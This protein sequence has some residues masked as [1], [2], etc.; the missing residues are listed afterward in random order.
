MILMVNGQIL[1]RLPISPPTTTN[2][3]RLIQTFLP[4]PNFNESARVLDD[5]RLGKQRVE[6]LQILNVLA[7]GPY[8]RAKCD[9]DTIFPVWESCPVDEWQKDKI[10]YEYRKT[11]WYNHP[12]VRMWR[13]WECTLTEY[14][15]TICT[16]WVKRGYKDTC[17][18]KI[19]HVHFGTPVKCHSVIERQQG[20]N[21]QSTPWLGDAKFHAAHRSNLLRKNPTH[22]SQFGWTEPHDLPYVWPV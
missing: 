14:A 1:P 17:A 3:F 13:G 20:H 5:K 10:N 22:Y 18:D 6:C 11:P 12:A 8:Q 4:Y 7:I 21:E 2:S 16:H 19:R 9:V 15:I